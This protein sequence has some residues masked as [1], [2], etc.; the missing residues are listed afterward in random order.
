MY[1]C[2]LYVSWNKQ[3]LFLYTALSGWLFFTESEG[4]FCA[5]R[6]KSMNIIPV[7]LSLYKLISSFFMM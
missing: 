2:V 7:I 6:A 4:V 1:L 3:G 5:V